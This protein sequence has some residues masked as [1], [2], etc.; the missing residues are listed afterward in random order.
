LKLRRN[1]IPQGG[2]LLDENEPISGLLVKDINKLEKVG[3]TTPIFPEI[4]FK[5]VK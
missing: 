2:F 1:F 5:V 4:T 3:K